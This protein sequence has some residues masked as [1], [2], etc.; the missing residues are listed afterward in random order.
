MYGGCQIIVVCALC[1]LA[2]ASAADETVH[3][4]SSSGA[5]FVKRIASVEEFESGILNNQDIWFV[6]FSAMSDDETK[7][8]GVNR[9]KCQKV[10]DS[11]IDIAV[12]MNA[13]GVQ[14]RVPFSSSAQSEAHSNHV[15][16]LRSS[17]AG[18]EGDQPG[19]ASLFT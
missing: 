2:I 3:D 15:F 7:L 19:K 14:V 12:A 9:E 13:H 18:K 6:V 10:Q 17:C 1:L 16:S 11:M 4:L 8:K 5:G